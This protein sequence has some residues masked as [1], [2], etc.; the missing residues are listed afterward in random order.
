[1]KITTIAIL[2]AALLRSN[3]A[4]AYPTSIIAAPSA[5]IQPRG[6]ISITSYNSVLVAP[7]Y[8]PYTSQIGFELSVF[9]NI[10][11]TPPEQAAF[12]GI[13]L[14]FDLLNA[15]LLGTPNAFVK[16]LLNAKI[17]ALT[18]SHTTPS[19]AFGV[20]D[21]APFQLNRSLNLVYF[22][23]SKTLVS[24][25]MNWGRFTLGLGRV[26]NSFSTESDPY[27]TSYP[28]FVG[29]WPF[30]KG[31]KMAL[32]AGYE[33]PLFGKVSFAFDYT[34]GASEIGETALMG[35]YSF[36]KNIV[37]GLGISSDNTTPTTG[38]VGFGFLSAQTHLF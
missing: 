23:A 2:T 19:I 18:E 16:P 36:M 8:A 6:T 34:G 7:S 31:S 9:S 26:A 30:S 37:G 35:A 33:T 1:M 25:K 13:E 22:V 12:G 17:L 21:V 5:A 27:A 20:M 3:S 28:V 32:L 38:I 10:R 24:P 4:D 14:G 29:T 11:D 15:D